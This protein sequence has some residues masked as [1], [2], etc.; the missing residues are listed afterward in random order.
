[1]AHLQITERY[2]G[3]PAGEVYQAGLKALPAAGFTIWK[4][5]DIAWLAMVRCGQAID[6]NLAIRPGSQATLNLD[7]PALSEV[8]L[9]ARAERLFG[10]MAKILG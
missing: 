3:K 1:V 7:A 4:Q 2:P 10:E 9:R 6:G 5:R 8:E